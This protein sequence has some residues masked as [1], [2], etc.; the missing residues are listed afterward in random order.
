MIVCSIARNFSLARIGYKW[1]WLWL[2][3]SAY[4]GK[5]KI[6]PLAG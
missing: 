1:E 5:T 4:G 2:E 6:S 3:G